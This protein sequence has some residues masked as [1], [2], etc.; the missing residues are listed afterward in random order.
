[1]LSSILQRKFNLPLPATNWTPAA[2]RD[3]L[4][5][6]NNEARRVETESNESISASRRVVE[7]HDKECGEARMAIQKLDMELSLKNDEF[8][9]IDRES[10][11]KRSELSRLGSSRNAIQQNQVDYESA[12]RAHDEFLASYTGKANDFKRQLKDATDQI[13][14]LADEIQS[15]S[16]L[17]QDLSIHR[18]EV[19]DDTWKDSGR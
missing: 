8:Q 17:L 5:T 2:A 9:G 10:A 6:I 13:R 7:G 19:S 3:Y 16:T 12:L 11:A 18:N 4:L 14:T 15:D 1:M